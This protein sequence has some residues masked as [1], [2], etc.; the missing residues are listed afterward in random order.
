MPSKNIFDI[1]KLKNDIF[2]IEEK[3]T[4]NTFWTQPPQERIPLLK[5]LSHKKQDFQEWE[6][7]TQEYENIEVSLELLKIESDDVLQQETQE[8][9]RVFHLLLNNLEIKNY[10][11]GEHD[12]ANVIV[13]IHSGAGG[14]EAMDWVGMLFRMYNRWAEKN[15]CACKVLDFLSGEETLYKSVTF[16]IQGRYTYGKLKNEVGVH[17]LVRISP[18]DA[19]KK[20]HTSFAS[21]FVFP[22]V[23]D[24]VTIEIQESELRIDTYRAS[25]AGGQHVN[26]TDSAVRITHTP[27]GIITQCQNERSQHQNK[28][29]A[30]KMLKAQLLEKRIQEQNVEKQK[31]EES[32][33]EIA[34]GHQIRSYVLQPYQMIK[35][36]RTSSETS[37]TQKFLDGEID[38][39]IEDLLKIK[40]DPA[41]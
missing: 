35:D 36:Y 12:Q 31:I 4:Q 2:E 16:S 27:T 34:W 28:A 19:N 5:E 25:G 21:V 32:K 15:S 20:R 41:T 33:T 3:T 40:K 11:S 37:Q 1:T 9:L 26:T 18:F 10:L 30:L 7:I 6:N 22:D 23:D 39:F 8:N 24:T 38:S 17:R 29:M 13:S 14:V